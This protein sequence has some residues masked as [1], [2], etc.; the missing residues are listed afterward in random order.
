[1]TDSHE[2]CRRKVEDHLL[3][4]IIDGSVEAGA[5]EPQPSRRQQSPAP[6]DVVFAAA[7]TTCNESLLPQPLVGRA[8]RSCRPRATGS[9][10]SCAFTDRD[11]RRSDR[12]MLAGQP[13]ATVW[14]VAVNGVMAGC[15][16][17]Y[18]PVLIAVVEA[19]A[20]PGLQGRGRGL[21]AR[22]GSSLIVLSGPIAKQ[23]GFNSR[24]GCHARRAS[25]PTPASA[26][27]CALSCA[28]SRA[29][30]TRRKA[31]TRAASPRASS[32]LP[33][34]TRPRRRARLAAVQ[35]RPR[36]QAGENI[37][38][39]QSVVAISAPA[40]SGSDRADEH[41]DELLA[42][43][44]G[45]SVPAVTGRA[46]GM[47]VLPTGI[48]SS[49]SA[50]ASRSVFAHDGWTQ[51]STSGATSTR[52][53]KIPPSRAER[54]AC[55]TGGQTGFASA[56]VTCESG[57][58][59]PRSTSLGRSRPARARSFST[60]NG[61]ASSS[62]ATRRATSRRATSATTCKGPPVSRRIELPADWRDRLAST[63]GRAWPK[64]PA[65]PR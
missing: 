38:T 41:A 8:A 14:N 33:Q 6:H 46:I 29:S 16:P 26:A 3:P 63:G 5:G 42:D 35:R 43:V 2:V 64:T 45:D 27:S 4:R 7:S 52:S 56:I 19:I 13:R 47:V 55:G 57:L 65:P 44:I 61:S 39:V 25:R 54:Y 23:L 48:R 12:N 49:C 32:S 62:R 50:R 60:R 34:K 15:R 28:I 51:G 31:P 30:I 22:G 21:D 40:Y 17:E 20:D 18:M 1:M 11:A 24:P 53:V 37:V 10:V 36:L 59:P 9:S 58:L